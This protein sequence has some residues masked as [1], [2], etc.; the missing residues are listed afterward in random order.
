MRAIEMIRNSKALLNKDL[1]AQFVASVDRNLA[2][3]ILFYNIATAGIKGFK[4]H[5][6]T[7]A[8]STYA[9]CEYVASKIIDIINRVNT[10]STDMYYDNA[11]YR[12]SI[13]KINFK[14]MGS[15]GYTSV[16]F[17][18]KGSYNLTTDCDIIDMIG[19]HILG[20]ITNTKFDNTKASKAEQV[21]MKIKIEKAFVTGLSDKRRSYISENFESLAEA[22]DIR[23]LNKDVIAAYHII[24][25][26][27][28]G[29]QIRWCSTYANDEYKMLHDWMKKNTVMELVDSY[30]DQSKS[31]NGGTF[32]NAADTY[33]AGNVKVIIDCGWSTY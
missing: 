8:I 20:I 32:C 5:N 18:I 16:S 33:M 23:F 10:G 21:D 24:K 12:D 1:N 6:I 22:R 14:S 9:Q 19:N 11:S 28:Q 7:P 27:K 29:T 31:Y 17:S 2:D 3:N 15:C 13:I 30:S 26:N 25:E 4:T